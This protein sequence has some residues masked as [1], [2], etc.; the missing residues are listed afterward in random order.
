MAVL[1][2]LASPAVRDVPRVEAHDSI[3]DT[4]LFQTN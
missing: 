3:S 4:H 2:K 1:P